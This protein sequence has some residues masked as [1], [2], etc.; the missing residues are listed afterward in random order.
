MA[1]VLSCNTAVLFVH[2]HSNGNRSIRASKNPFSKPA[3]F[4]ADAPPELSA[5]SHKRSK[6]RG[7]VS[8]R[9]AGNLFCA[10]FAL[11]ATQV[12]WRKNVFIFAFVIEIKVFVKEQSIS[13]NPKRLH[14]INYSVGLFFG[15]KI[16][17]ITK[18]INHMMM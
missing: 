4:G 17:A 12:Y 15:T 8:H 6:G 11:R 13:V 10:R 18:A 3:L 5:A 1:A 7:L 9:G 14:H 2:F 16:G